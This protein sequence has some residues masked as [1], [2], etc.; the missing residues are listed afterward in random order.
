MERSQRTRIGSRF[1]AHLNGK[2]IVCLDIA[3]TYKFME[4]T[5]GRLLEAKVGPHLRSR[6]G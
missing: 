2:R 3:D 1:R 4:P 5:L 6:G